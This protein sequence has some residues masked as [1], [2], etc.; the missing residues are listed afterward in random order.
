MTDKDILHGSDYISR[1]YEGD[2][3][4]ED[5]SLEC[6]PN[7]IGDTENES[8][9]LPCRFALSYTVINTLSNAKQ[10][11]F[12]VKGEMAVKQAKGVMAKFNKSIE[13]EGLEWD[14]VLNDNLK[15]RER[16]LKRTFTILLTAKKPIFCSIN[17][18][19]PDS[20]ASAFRELTTMIMRIQ[21]AAFLGLFWPFSKAYSYI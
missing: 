13:E 3:E 6:I 14:S 7:L 10:E 16:F 20:A 17:L 11:A 5:F 4:R 12:K 8:L 15:A 18:A 21:L 19:Y 1:L 9:N 2:S